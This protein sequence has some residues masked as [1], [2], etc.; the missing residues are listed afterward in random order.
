MSKLSYVST[1][2]YTDATVDCQTIIIDCRLLVIICSTNHFDSLHPKLFFN[3]GEASEEEKN[4]E[5]KN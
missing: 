2:D 3:R 5:M 4:Y 1:I